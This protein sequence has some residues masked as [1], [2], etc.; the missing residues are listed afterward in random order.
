MDLT[1]VSSVAPAGSR[2]RLPAKGGFASGRNST[3]TNSS[4]RA[5]PA[6]QR[7]LLGSRPPARKPRSGLSSVFSGHTRLPPRLADAA[8]LLRPVPLQR[9]RRSRTATPR[10]ST[11]SGPASPRR[12][13][14]PERRRPDRHPSRLWGMQ[15]AAGL[16]DSACSNS[17][18]AHPWCGW[19]ERP[20]RSIR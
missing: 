20:A 12:C 1:V 18:F 11:Q 19:E 14:I 13:G 2:A 7:S 9:G 10:K 17:A 5:E 16:N 4:R 8:N 6:G 3:C 15:K